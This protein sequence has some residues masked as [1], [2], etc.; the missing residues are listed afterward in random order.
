MKRQYTTLQ[1]LLVG[2][3]IGLIAGVIVVDLVLPVGVVT[4]AL[5]V[6]L[7]MISLVS[8][9]RVF[10][11][12]IAAAC[13]GLIAYEFV[14]LPL[15]QWSVSWLPVVARVLALFAIWDTAI[16]SLLHREAEAEVKR[17]EQLLSICPTCKKIRNDQGQWQGVEA[18]IRA[19]SGR[20][21]YPGLCPEC[22]KDWTP[23][24]VLLRNA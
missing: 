15:K 5:Y 23:G 24:E 12:L 2:M 3:A 13:T 7:V 14:S 17:L 9:T 18:Y 8:K 11:L 6:S 19:N 22:R 21:S 20:Q 10:P 1:P 16:L 4:G